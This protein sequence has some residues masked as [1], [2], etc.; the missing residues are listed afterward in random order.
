M[1]SFSGSLI[2][3]PVILLAVLLISSRVS[4]QP[5]TFPCLLVSASDDEV[6]AFSGEF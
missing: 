5:L 4:F 3:T 1:K 2:T 6:V